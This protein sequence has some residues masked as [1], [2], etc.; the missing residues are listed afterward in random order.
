MAIHGRS[1]QPSLLLPSSSI[2]AIPLLRPSS[3]RLW[4][5]FHLDRFEWAGEACLQFYSELL[6]QETIRSA[7]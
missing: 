4:F 6:V 2:D 3:E 5:E 7:L 1:V